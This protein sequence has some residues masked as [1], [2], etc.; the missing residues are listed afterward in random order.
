MFCI[1]V[2][3]T[4]IN[5]SIEPTK[6]LRGVET[7]LREAME[8][9]YFAYRAFTG[10]GDAL[11]AADGFGRAHHRVLYFVGREPGMTVGGLLNTL[12]ISK[13]AL[14]PV[15]RQ[16]VD[17]GLVAQT[18]GESDKRERCLSLSADGAVLERSIAERQMAYI[19]QSFDAAGPGA[20]AG[21]R[22]VVLGLVEPDL[23]ARFDQILDIG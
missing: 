15:L 20:V 1:Y 10:E 14:A 12:Q 8:L 17:K 9:L 5:A 4:D 7:D 13:Q 22:Q 21:F 23:R 6:E 2:N 19:R 16:L 3:M 11:L 18:P